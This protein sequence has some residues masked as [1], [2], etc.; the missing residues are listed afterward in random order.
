MI[1]STTNISHKFQPNISLRLLNWSQKY[2][3]VSVTVVTFEAATLLC[4][5]CKM[6]K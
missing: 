3:V 2:V 4:V 5:F 1:K 6:K